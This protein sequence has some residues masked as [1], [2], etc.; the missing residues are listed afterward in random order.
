VAGNI[1]GAGHEL[2]L[3][4]NL[5]NTRWELLNPAV[6]LSTIGAEP[7]DATILK[8]AGANLTGGINSARGNITQH[9]TTMD[10]FSVTSPDILDGTGS[11]VTITACVNA[12]QAGATRKFYPIVATVLTH[13]ATFDIAGNANLTAAAGDCWIIEAK[14][15]STYRVTAV[16]EDGTAVVSGGGGSQI[17][18]IS[19]SVAGN[20]LTITAPSLTLDF[21]SATLTSGTVTTVTSDPADLV[22]SSGSTLGTVSG[23]ASRLAVI[24][25]N[26]AGTIELAVRNVSA[27][28]NLDEGAL[29]S[30]TAEGGAGAA[31][32][33]TVNYSTT[34]RS[35]LAFRVI[36]YLESTQATAGTWVTNPST[37]QGEGGN[38]RAVKSA[39]VIGT[40]IAAAS[41]TSID[42]TGIPAWATEVVVSILGGSLNASDAFLV[43]LGDAGGIETTGYSGTYIQIDS[44]GTALSSGF[45]DIANA[46][47]DTKTGVYRLL[48]IDRATNTWHCV[49]SMSRIGTGDCS[50]IFGSKS[51]SD[52]LT[53][54]RLTSGTGTST[55]DVG[56]FNYQYR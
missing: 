35:N 36:G 31:D 22:V 12:P 38:A 18:P 4:Y 53:Q 6:T 45:R 29:I 43:Q 7:A 1:A 20:A 39:W 26:N 56:T 28:A 19:A 24:A 50:S 32:S 41:Q 15:A 3:K 37:I 54:V 23:I 17:Q 13:G 21:R 11:A 40:P 16:K 51:L 44:T 25:M 46:A 34:A 14:T 33:A 49:G 48:L 55:M 10:F 30:T 42:F 2:E 8:R 27:G 52:T 47:A 9:A 5:A